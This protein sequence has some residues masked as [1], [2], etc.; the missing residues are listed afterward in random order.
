MSEDEK[1]VLQSKIA[2]IGVACRFPGAA[3]PEQFW[4][5]IIT[6]PDEI[7]KADNREAAAGRGTT[8]DDR[9]RAD[10]FD[11]DFFSIDRK[12][13]EFLD[14]QHR[15]LLECAWEAMEDS[16]HDLTSEEGSVGVF[17]ACSLSSYL[18][19]ILSTANWRR[20]NSW[21]NLVRANDKDYLPNRISSHLSLN[22]PSLA[23]Q[24]GSS[25]SLVAIATAC[26]SL[27]SFECDIAI[28]GGVSI[29]TGTEEAGAS[30]HPLRSIS[31]P[32]EN[33][34]GVVILRRLEDATA[35][36]DNIRAVILGTAVNNDGDRRTPYKNSSMDAQVDVIALAQGVASITPKSVG[37]LQMH[38]A[39]DSNSAQIELTALLRVF[40]NSDNSQPWCGLGS[41]KSR[42]GNL[43]AAGGIASFIMA[44]LA[45]EHKQIPPA[46]RISK[47]PS[48][49]SY[50]KS[51]YSPAQLMSWPNGQSLRRAGVSSF[52]DGGTNVH[53]VL[54]EAPEPEPLGRDSGAHLV[55]VLSANSPERLEQFQA[56]LSN[57]I[58]SSRV[59]LSA[60]AY[61]LQVGRKHFEWRTSFVGADRAEIIRHLSEPYE[62]A[63]VK[64]PDWSD[65][66]SV[67]LM[68]GLGTHYPGMAGRLYATEPF[69]AREIDA[70]CQILMETIAEDIRPSILSPA[71]DFD[72]NSNPSKE[73]FDFAHMV[74]NP[75]PNSRNDDPV[76]AQL[77]LFVVEY[78]LAR[79]FQH[80]GLQPSAIL[81]YSIGEY[82][83][84]CI[85][86][87]F[88]RE[89][90]LQIIA[91]RSLLTESLPPGSMIA[92]PLGETD[93]LPL[94]N[95]RVFFCGSHGPTLSILGGTVDAISELQERLTLK[96]IVTRRLRT[97]RAFHTPLMRPVA[98]ALR[99]VISR[100]PLSQPS[101]P[102][103]SNLTG[104]WVRGDEATSPDYW[105]NHLC[106]PV[107]FASGVTAIGISGRRLFLEVGP[108][109]SLC[110]L[111]AAQSFADGIDDAVFVSTMPSVYESIASDST[112]MNAIACLWKYG[113]EIDWKRLHEGRQLRRVSLPT[114]P[115]IQ[116]SYWLQPSQLAEFAEVS[117]D[118]AE[119]TKNVYARSTVTIPEAESSERTSTISD[120]VLGAARGVT[121]SSAR[122][123]V[124]ESFGDLGSS[125]GQPS[126]Q[127]EKRVA[128]IWREK[129]V[130]SQLGPH[131]DFFDLGGDSLIA[132]QIL[133]RVRQDFGVQIGLQSFLRSP[134]IAALASKVDEMLAAQKAENAP[135]K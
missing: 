18:I 53:A 46:P 35:A 50:N 96:E 86:G 106:S 58:E 107:R 122:H 12:D 38:G 8:P 67:F 98:K 93:V 13:A 113:V 43:E 5:R 63:V 83:A 85:A 135:P 11:A 80:W 33:G 41:V 30:H 28:V 82:V 128:A 125:L 20:S 14:P 6:V 15:V 119:T 57:H 109:R 42:F 100:E 9:L 69:F 55:F 60:A 16:G 111:A 37:Y 99:E 84:A 121:K 68:P 71:E 133:V 3:T 65:R 116:Q 97:T 34:A 101:I 112:V 95:D 126:T 17:A 87:V 92:V 49:H 117:T 44:V 103:V 123:M 76:T 1:S 114:S 32:A 88:S 39:M 124:R 70:C 110:G 90:A 2:V 47:F 7:C 51:F 89:S 78:A 94:L 72:G 120:P 48:F 56:R 77:G 24:A 134:R 61:T 132:I 115:F 22:G 73:R 40:N 66:R 26:R 75:K 79:L 64:V 104:T 31:N 10:L 108:G 27:E 19:R 105:A 102:Y 25:S 36:G 21:T 4:Q 129:F 91:Q 81:G 127:T 52:G 74:A 45:L 131:D 62:Q 118:T 29:G 23:I 54:Q 130:E 59:N